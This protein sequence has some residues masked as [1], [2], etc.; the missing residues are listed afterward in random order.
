MERKKIKRCS[1]NINN[2]KIRT[3]NA[4]NSDAIEKLYNIE[5]NTDDN[6]IFTGSGGSYAASIFSSIVIND[7][8]GSNTFAMLP[9]DII[10]R[11]NSKVNKVIL[12]SYSGTTNDLLISTKYIITKG[13]L[14]KI[15]LKTNIVKDNIITYRT[16]NN[17]GKERGFLSFEGTISP[18]SLFL[19]YY[20][21]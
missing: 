7:L 9:R 10:Y 1:I 6:Y 12:F 16:S 17:R 8:Y 5:F 2:L 3:L 11:N 21:N 19:K 20:F 18:S 13:E 14:S 15:V 4:I